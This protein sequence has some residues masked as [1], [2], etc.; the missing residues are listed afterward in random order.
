[1]Q[2]HFMLIS[3][4]AVDFVNP[5]Q[6]PV[7]VGDCPLCAQQ[8]KGQR[9]FPDEIGESTMVCFVGFIHTEMASQQYGGKLLAKSGWGWTFSLAPGVA[10]SLLGSSHVK[11][12]QYSYQLTLAWLHALKVHGD[13]GKETYCKCSN[14]LL[15]VNSPRISP[16]LLPLS[17]R[18]ANG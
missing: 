12:T 3:K 14:C 17:A 9:R 4:K 8:K 11:R 15:L 18:S 5:G 16:G 10:A 2:K 7:I 1:M 6:I 13:V